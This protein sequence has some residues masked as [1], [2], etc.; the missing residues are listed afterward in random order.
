MNY[1]KNELLERIDNFLNKFGPPGPPPKSHWKWHEPTHRW[2]NPANWIESDGHDAYIENL[3]NRDKRIRERMVNYYDS[4]KN[5]AHRKRDR[6]SP[7]GATFVLGSLNRLNEVIRSASMYNFSD[8]VKPHIDNVVSAA[9]KEHEI[10]DSPFTKILVNR[11]K[12]LQTFIEENKFDEEE[13]QES[14]HYEPGISTATGKELEAHPD[15][16]EEF[17]KK[18]PQTRLRFGEGETFDEVAKSDEMDNTR[19]KLRDNTF[20]FFTSIK[21]E[22]QKQVWNILSQDKSTIIYT[23]KRWEQEHASFNSSIW[24]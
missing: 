22:Y 9:E 20:R 21:P 8:N 4:L 3:S 6:M 17:A 7:T 11:A 14:D 19:K 5:F 10:T 15:M 16:N 13:K 2:R 24:R 12:R 18:K 23:E 1:D